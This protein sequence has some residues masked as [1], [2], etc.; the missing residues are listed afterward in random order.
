MNNQRANQNQKEAPL[1]PLHFGT[2][3]KTWIIH[4]VGKDVEPPNAYIVLVQCKLLELH[5]KAI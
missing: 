2:I 3:K 4:S 5:G 1:H